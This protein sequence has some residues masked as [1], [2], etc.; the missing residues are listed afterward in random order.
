MATI[1]ARVLNT[2]SNTTDVYLAIECTTATAQTATDC[3]IDPELSADTLNT[4]IAEKARAAIADAT[5][6]E[7]PSDTPVVLLGGL[8][9]VE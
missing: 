7:V 5:N 3:Y 9:K 8:T 2:N 4:I 6:E 1:V